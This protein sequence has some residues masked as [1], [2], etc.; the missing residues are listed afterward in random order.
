M[1]MPWTPY[2]FLTRADSC[3]MK[4]DSICGVS[5]FSMVAIFVA[6]GMRVA[7][8]TVAAYCAAS[9][10]YSGFEECDEF[11][12]LVVSSIALTN[13]MGVGLNVQSVMPMW[14]DSH[15]AGL[16]AKKALYSIM[17][18]LTL[19]P[20]GSHCALMSCAYCGTSRKFMVVRW[21]ASPSG[22][23]ASVSSCFALA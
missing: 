11:H 17:S 21:S 13:W 7:S 9:L 4:K 14:T 10:S 6:M 2:K 22:C 3:V 18:M 12:T 16:P 1:L 23:P 20:A 19:I 15:G 8:S 5:S